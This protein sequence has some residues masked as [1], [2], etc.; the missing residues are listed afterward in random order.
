MGFETH[1]FGNIGYW[2]HWK[3]NPLTYKDLG[4]EGLDFGMIQLG[5]SIDKCVL[6]QNISQI[7]VRVN[8]ELESSNF[9][10]YIDESVSEMEFIDKNQFLKQK[11]ADELKKAKRLILELLWPLG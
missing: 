3:V 8:F 9:L 1:D 6:V 11:K 7:P 4:P 2:R 10:F 5:S